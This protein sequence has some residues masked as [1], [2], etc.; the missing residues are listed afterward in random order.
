MGKKTFVQQIVLYLG[1]L[2]GLLLT[3]LVLFLGSSYIVLEGELK[4]A[5]DAF[6]QIYTNEFNNSIVKMNG[7]L[8]NIAYQGEDLEKLGSSEENDRSLA[9]I[10]L[11][12]YM[13]DIVMENKI[14]DAVVVYDDSYGVCLDADNN[15][16]YDEKARMREF[17]KTALKDEKLE[18]GEW[19]FVYIEDQLYLF[20][21][22]KFNNRIIA[23]YVRN[24][25][26]LSAM[27][28]EESVS[29]SIVLADQKGEIGKVWGAEN[30]DICVGRKIEDAVSDRYYS[31]F[32]RTSEE[33][34]QLYCFT[35]K[36]VILQQTHISMIVVL[37]SVCGT[38]MFMLFLFQ[39]T[40]KEISRPMKQVIHDMERIK[41]GEYENRVEG[42]F[43]MEEFQVLQTTVNQ[44]IDEILDLKIRSYEKKIELQ[45]MELK[46]IRLQLK[47]HFFLNA[48]TTISSL[49]TQGKNVQIKKYIEALSRN[50]RYMF[51][52]GFHT[53]PLREE[54]RHVENYFEM[55]ELK[56]PGCIFYLIDMPKEA[57]EWNVPQMLI[58]TFIENEYK[59]AISVDEVL[60]LLIKV[61]IQVRNNEEMLLIEIEDDGKGY[62]EEVLDYMAGKTAC[63]SGKGTRIGLWSIKRM[64]ELMYER[65]DLLFLQNVSPHGCLNKIYLPKRAVHELSEE[66]I[67]NGM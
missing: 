60:T 65:E 39:F 32:R 1:I 21:P 29:R 10:S 24:D 34:L 25:H 19:C 23:L 2:G 17:A 14:I 7:V 50:I 6:L 11:Y 31:I 44:M 3:I 13:Q 12:N 54:I 18:N 8:M 48:L 37:L 56:Y 15:V 58:H 16:Y 27:E 53:V 5:S 55:Q 51:R 36:D 30:E 57:E 45:D 35:S 9:A 43:H 63:V 66:Q 46:S 22:V 40:R 64:L 61:S 20:K 67:Q 28:A 33:Q 52:A 4:E 42:K 41:N 47:P 38:F 62:P 49:S 26:L 59:Y